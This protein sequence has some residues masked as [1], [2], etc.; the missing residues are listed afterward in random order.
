MRLLV[1]AAILIA[2]P[3]APLSYGRGSVP[4]QNRARQQAGLA[5]AQSS[6]VAEIEKWRRTREENLKKDDGWLTVAGLFWLEPGN[7]R[8][9][10]ASSNSVVLPPGSAPPRIGNFFFKDGNVKFTAEPGVEVTSSGKRVQTLEMRSDVPGPADIITVKGLSMFV[11]KR[12]ERFAIRLRDT[13]SSFRREFTGLHWFPVDE[14]W[15]ITAEF[16]PYNPPKQIPVLDITGNTERQPCPGYAVFQI[17]RKQY[18]LEPVAEGDRLFFIF[19][20]QTAGKETYPAGRFF[21]SDAPRDGK[22]VLDFN[23]AYNPPCAFTPYATCPLPPAQNRLAVRI[24]AGELVYH[25]PQTG[26]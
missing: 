13:N 10:T 19:R 2:S 18:R 4:E 21:Y 3:K 15:R 25:H 12:G 22:V 5:L 24:P 7:N 17:D 16:V 26:K 9:G 1:A 20:D 11:I 23:K 8:A 6:Y 14:A